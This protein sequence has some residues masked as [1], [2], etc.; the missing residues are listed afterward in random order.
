VLAR[1]FVPESPVRSGGRIN[2]QSAVLLSGWLVAL[3]LPLSESRQSGWGS[4]AVLG[5][6]ALAVV[7]FGLWVTNE[8]RSDNAVIDMRMMRLPGVWTT[9][10]V[11]LLFG[12]GMF[13]VMAFLPQLARTPTSAGYGFGSSVTQAGLLM[14]P[15]GITM[16][17]A[18]FLSGPLVPYLSF[19]LQLGIGSALGAV[20]CAMFAGLHGAAWEIAV[21]TAIFGIGIGLA[22]ASMASLIVQ[23]VPSGQTGAATGRN[24]N[25]RTI[26]GAIGTAVL[27][28]AITGNLQP[29]GVPVES[30]FT[31]AFIALTVIGVLAVGISTI[32]PG[33]GRSRSRRPEELGAATPVSAE[34]G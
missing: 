3:L 31:N 23:G 16:G 13:S 12:A 33:S 18:G 7:L 28:S 21:A 22:Y 15:M 10:L 5:L 19:K 1:L 11:A 27:S 17:I 4:P 8:V 34:M 9:N 24:A 14:L 20:G 32:V 25:I 29:S 30:G 6:L 26:G 2:W